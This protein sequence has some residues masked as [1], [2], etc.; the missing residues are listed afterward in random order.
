[1]RANFFNIVILVGIRRRTHQ[2]KHFVRTTRSARRPRSRRW[3]WKRISGYN[4]F[5]WKNTATNFF[6]ICQ[7]TPIVFSYLEF[8]RVCKKW[9]IWDDCFFFHSY[10]SSY[11]NWISQIILIQYLGIQSLFLFIHLFN[12]R[13]KNRPE[14]HNW[15]LENTLKRKTSENFYT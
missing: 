3:K 11:S 12:I 10:Q 2:L 13:N 5:Q 6:L 1:M 14:N 15:Y 7:S 9:I 8:L 4:S